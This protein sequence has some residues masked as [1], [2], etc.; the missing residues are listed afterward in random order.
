MKSERN[1]KNCVKFKIY[2]GDWWG[3]LNIIIQVAIN[4]MPSPFI[5]LYKLLSQILK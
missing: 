3:K 1:V 2:Q 5:V 4:E